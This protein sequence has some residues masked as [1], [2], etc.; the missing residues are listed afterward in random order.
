MITEHTESRRRDERAEPSDEV[1]TARAVHASADVDTLVHDADDDLRCASAVDERMI[2]LALDPK[3][4]VL[5]W[6]L[7]GEGGAT[8]CGVEATALWR[9]LVMPGAVDVVLVHNH[10]S[11]LMRTTRLRR[12]ASDEPVRGRLRVAGLRI[13][14]PPAREL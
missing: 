13:V 3:N 1:D 12:P 14:V 6:H 11:G 9:T 2:A 5:S 4:R 10:P 7:V 8:S